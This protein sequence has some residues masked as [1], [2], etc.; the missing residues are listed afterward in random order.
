M[1]LIKIRK[2]ATEAAAYPHAACLTQ[3]R[4]RVGYGA[5]HNVQYKF[6]VI[7]CRNEEVNF[8]GSSANI[9]KPKMKWPMT[10][11]RADGQ[12]DRRSPLHTKRNT[13]PQLTNL[14]ITKRFS[15][16]TIELRF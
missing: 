3:G 6:E 10:D 16:K 1:H 11:G 15:K 13:L 8:Q 2:S 7:R 4:P 14:K 9:F 5:M 12:T